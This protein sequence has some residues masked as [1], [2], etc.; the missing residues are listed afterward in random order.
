M[1]RIQKFSLVV[2]FLILLAPTQVCPWATLSEKIA[3]T[4]DEIA[5]IRDLI[6]KFGADSTTQLREFEDR[7][8]PHPIHQFICW[9]AF[10]LLSEDPAFKDGKS[11]FPDI[12]EINSWDGIFHVPGAMRER[13]SSGMETGYEVIVPPKTAGIGGPSCDAEQLPD[14]SWNKNYIGSAHYYN[15]WFKWGRAPELAGHFYH[16]LTR[17]IVSGIGT[18]DKAHFAAHMAHYIAD[19]CSAKHADV[20]PIDNELLPKLVKIAQ[21]WEPKKSND[22]NAYVNDPLVVRAVNLISSDIRNKYGDIADKYWERVQKYIGIEFL[23][24]G[25]GFKY[26][27]APVNLNS[28][29]AAYLQEL[30]THPAGK[31]LNQFYNYFDPFYWNGPIVD[32]IGIYPTFQLATPASEH[33]RWETNPA[34][35]QTVIDCVSGGKR[36]VPKG[37]SG[38]WIEVSKDSGYFGPTAKEISPA[39]KKYL[40][41]LVVKV[42]DDTHKTIDSDVDFQAD[43]SVQMRTSIQAVYTAFRA[44]ISALRVEAKYTETKTPGKYRITFTIN[45]LADENCN[46]KFATVVQKIGDKYTFGSNSNLP[47][48]GS[49]PGGGK[50]KLFVEVDGLDFTKNE[51]A[52]DIHGSYDKTP[53]CG[54][55][56]SPIEKGGAK[57]YR[58]PGSVPTDGKGPI[59]VVVVFDITSSMGSS[60]G[61][62]KKNTI[63][64]LEKLKKQSDD[65]RLALVTFK[66][67]ESDKNPIT[68]TPFQKEIGS[69]LTAI[70]N[71]SPEGGGNTP[72]DQLA[73]IKAGL[74]L[75]VKEGV[76]SRTPTKI[77][78]VVTDAEAKDPDSQGNTAKSIAKLAFE[79]DPAHIYPI[80]VGSSELAK[81]TG[82]ELAELTNG[83]MLESETGEDVAE[84]L[85]SAIEIGV[86]E[87]GDEA[88]Q[89]TQNKGKMFL[90]AGGGIALIAIAVFLF[91]KSKRK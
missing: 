11:G 13:G 38:T 2:C 41:D 19:A 3:M 69:I 91:S 22:Q 32:G 27:V 39:L 68:I 49:V 59:D 34:H 66:D 62:M 21:E 82:K 18:N 31:E 88:V 46:L 45:N 6:S 35:Y 40:S 72:E 47:L 73:G 57:I 42:A 70:G 60:I 61:A 55:R 75:W 50:L 44:S 14:G 53:D 16:H 56:R 37:G 17:S 15:P 1:K 54:W 77:V 29:V 25:A 52:L 90:F 51:Y 83:K 71:L 28:A 78:I 87:H 9:Q 36:I 65:M 80:V 48:T 64:V 67:L 79:V 33:L 74:D 12:L 8:G 10:V 26:D 84:K 89:P 81:K 24:P 43:Y 20:V 7:R 58:S 86:V 63:A 30:A 76:T 5:T 85:V 4:S 23:K